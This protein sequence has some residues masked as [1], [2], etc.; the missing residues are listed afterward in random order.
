M[1]DFVIR[2]FECGAYTTFFVTEEGQ[3]Y[4]CGGNSHGELGTNTQK[5]FCLPHKIDTKGIIVKEIAAGDSHTLFLS[6]QGNIYACGNG[7]EGQ[8]GTRE[9][10]EDFSSTKLQKIEIKEKF[11]KVSASNYSAAISSKG[12]VFVWGTSVFGTYST[13]TIFTKICKRF[14]EL[15]IGADSGYALTEDGE[16]WVW[17]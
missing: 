10:Y 16:V 12:T 7:K 1:A 5:H 9:N 14:A 2:D 13:P 17:G 15:S 8:L 3:T 4:G 11:I 6:K